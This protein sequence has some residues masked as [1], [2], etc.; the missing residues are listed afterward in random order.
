MMLR[1]AAPRPSKR[2]A[3]A[4]SVNASQRTAAP[5]TAAVAAPS[6]SSPADGETKALSFRETQKIFRH[7]STAE[8]LRAY[9]VFGLSQIQPFVQHSDTLIKAAYAFPGPQITNKL[10]RATFFGHFCAGEDANEIRPVLKKLENA[11][12]GAILD[13]AAEADVDHP[14]D[15]NGVSQNLVSA[16]TY[17]YEDESTCDANAAI[18]R[19]AIIDAGASKAAGEPAFAA[20]KCTALGKPELLMRMSS[21][22]VQAQ[23]LFHTLDGPNLSRAKTQYLKKLVDY[24]TLSAG[25][26]NAGLEMS[27]TD[28]G[29]LFEALDVSKDGVI[30][31]VDWVSYLDPF[32]LTMGPLTQFIQE[33][34]LD[35]RE[36]TQLRNMIHRLE[37]L[38]SEAAEQGVKLMVDAEQTYM[39]PGIDHLVLNL[40]RKYNRENRDVIYNTFQCYLKISNDRVDIDLERARRENFRFACK[41]VRGA[42]MVQERKRAQDM[43]YA[44]PI[45]NTIED[46]HNNYNAQVEKLLRNNAIA[47]FMVA[48]HN[49]D[50]VKN[51][52]RLMDELNIDRRRGGVYFGQLLGMC[53]HVSYTLGDHKYRVFKYVPYGPIG[54]VLPYLVRRAQENSG[55]M[56]GATKEMT[57][58]KKEVLRRAVGGR[59]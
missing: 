38:A 46:T 22:I 25:L 19:Q 17:D 39:Q 15:L 7:K 10:L 21:I 58:I 32:D 14:R 59:A 36:K 6:L 50:S 49:E 45:H 43:S 2:L 28:V 4:L 29:K 23:L 33:K 41:L 47:S 44:D 16:R 5:A 27:E 51:T 12:I 42:Y 1:H 37:G 40:Q 34:P 18:A 56:S 20:I 52:V 53:D 13:Y 48:S 8:L 11:G 30:D 55:L 31:Y 9:A 3:R 57:L 35:D 24:P 54:E 26:R